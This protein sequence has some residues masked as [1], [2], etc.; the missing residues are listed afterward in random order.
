MTSEALHNTGG[1]IPSA[2][3]P[4]RNAARED[5]TWGAMSSQQRGLEKGHVLGGI[6]TGEL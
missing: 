1:G 4:E 5:L 6:D 2:P 3:G